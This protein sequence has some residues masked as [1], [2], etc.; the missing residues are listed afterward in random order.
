[1]AC[2]IPGLFQLNLSHPTVCNKKQNSP[3]LHA[4][5]HASEA[6]VCDWAYHGP[7]CL[8]IWSSTRFWAHTKCIELISLTSQQ[9]KSRAN[10]QLKNSFQTHDIEFNNWCDRARIHTTQLIWEK[11][12]HDLF[13]S[14]AFCQTALFY[15]GRVFLDHAR[16]CKYECY[17][18]QSIINVTQGC[19][20]RLFFSWRFYL[21]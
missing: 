21:Q 6:S 17:Q 7:I 19:S 8:H 16:Q 18:R 1:M 5:Q 10:F 9:Q 3:S 20:L 11:F 15:L 4:Q 13:Q 12:E 2:C 14:E